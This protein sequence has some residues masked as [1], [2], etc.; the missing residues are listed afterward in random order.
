MP[1]SVV[2]NDGVR[3]ILAWVPGEIPTTG[4]P[5]QLGPEDSSE[6]IAP[7]AQSAPVESSPDIVATPND[8]APAPFQLNEAEVA[9]PGFNAVPGGR[10]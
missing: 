9:Q 1:N 4:N 7:G 8:L 6:V 3:D 5:V 2:W 10:R